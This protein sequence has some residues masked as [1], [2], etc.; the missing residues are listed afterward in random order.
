MKA[1][2]IIEIIIVLI[3]TSVVVSASM[4]LYTN[5]HKIQDSCLN[6]GQTEASF[7]LLCDVLRKDCKE[8]KSLSYVNNDLVCIKEKEQVAY[9][10]E[11]NQIIR[12]AAIVDSFQFAC[13]LPEITYAKD[14]SYIQSIFLT[15]LLNND[16][17]PVY[18]YKTDFP[19]N[20]L[21]Q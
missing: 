1:F 9:T 12:K 6:Q 5:M 3:I 18:I 19:N 16:S 15:F 7:V 4:F 14:Q 17:I 10:F 8:A 2:T 21:N 13:S 20:I 11:S